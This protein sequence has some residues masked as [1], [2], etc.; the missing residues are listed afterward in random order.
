LDTKEN[1]IRVTDK[2]TSVSFLLSVYDISSADNDKQHHC[3]ITTTS[4]IICYY[5]F[6]VLS[7]ILKFPR[8]S[9][10][11]IHKG[12]MVCCDHILI[13]DKEHFKASEISMLNGTVIKGSREFHDEAELHFANDKAPNWK[14][15]FEGNFFN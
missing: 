9:F 1:H 2:K 15:R 13:L 10:W 5:P 4:G 14:K 12:K 6:S 3:A 7:L 11:L 8:L